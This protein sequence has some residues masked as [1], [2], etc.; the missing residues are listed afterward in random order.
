MRY[1]CRNYIRLGVHACVI[2]KRVKIKCY[3]TTYAISISK[4]V[5]YIIEM[6]KKTLGMPYRQ[7]FCLFNTFSNA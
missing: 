4:A 1:R 3:V 6:R 5:C 7:V 2:R